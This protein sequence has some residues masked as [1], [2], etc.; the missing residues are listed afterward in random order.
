MS[1]KVIRADAGV[2]FHLDMKDCEIF[3]TAQKDG[4]FACAPFSTNTCDLAH[5]NGISNTIHESDDPI[6]AV[7]EDSQWLWQPQL[8]Q[9]RAT[10]KKIK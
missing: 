7:R 8:R 6:G 9:L 4:Q 1:Q 2:A 3:N 5:A 10:W